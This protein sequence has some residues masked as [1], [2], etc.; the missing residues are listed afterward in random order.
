MFSIAC[1]V[2]AG[3]CCRKLH[4]CT[5]RGAELDGREGGIEV[6]E[7]LKGGIEGRYSCMMATELYKLPIGQTLSYIWLY[8]TS[9]DLCEYCTA[10]YIYIIIIHD[11]SC[12]IMNVVTCIF[13]LIKKHYTN[14]PQTSVNCSM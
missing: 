14:S 11:Y 13:L 7:V 8:C 4:I 6:R 5:E 3:F 1:E 2:G 9:H 12:I 10:L